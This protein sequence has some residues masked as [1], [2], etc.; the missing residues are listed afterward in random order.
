[1]S[2]FLLLS[3]DPNAWRALRE[4]TVSETQD[5]SKYKP[6]LPE[7]LSLAALGYQVGLTWN[8]SFMPVNSYTRDE[9]DRLL[10]CLTISRLC[11]E[12]WN[13]WHAGFYQGVAEN[14][15]L[16]EI[17]RNKF[18]CFEIINTN[19]RRTFAPIS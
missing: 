17:D 1:M 13:A 10:G 19:P 4:Q 14:S 2:K 9:R 11:W 15:N 16:R 6:S 5:Q 12:A 7:L 8:K 18:H 3:A